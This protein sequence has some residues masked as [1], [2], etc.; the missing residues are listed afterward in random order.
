MADALQAIVAGVA[1]VKNA[2][3]SRAIRRKDQEM[4]QLILMVIPRAQAPA[5]C[6][7]IIMRHHHPWPG[8]HHLCRSVCKQVAEARSPGRSVVLA[9]DRVNTALRGRGAV[10]PKVTTAHI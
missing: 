7:L 5:Q 4:N 1:V 10:T 8:C 6:I 3:L 2:A 9:A